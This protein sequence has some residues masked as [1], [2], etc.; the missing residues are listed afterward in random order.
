LDLSLREKDDMV[1]AR[2]IGAGDLRLIFR[3]MLPNAL[4]PIIVALT[5]GIPTTIFTEA[6]LSFIGA[7]IAPPQTS[8]GYMVGENQY[9]SA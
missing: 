1:A 4:T 3:H 6:F 9:Y 8:W 2:L 7:G 5:F